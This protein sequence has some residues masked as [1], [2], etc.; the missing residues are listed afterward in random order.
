MRKRHKE[1]KAMQGRRIGV[2]MGGDASQEER[3]LGIGDLV[4]RALT[5]RGYDAVRIYVDSEI[6]LAVRAAQIDVAFLALAG[7]RGLS[8][9]VQGLLELLD[10][11]YTGSSILATA[12]ATDKLKA[13]ELF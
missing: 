12:L 13:K 7:P 10:I 9:S 2:L 4:C 3:W 5:D 1:S 8:G 6:D 11:P